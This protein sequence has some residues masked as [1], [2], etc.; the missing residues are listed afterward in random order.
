MIEEI[1]E[2]TDAVIGQASQLLP[3]G[4]PADL[5][6][7]IFSGMKKHRAKLAHMR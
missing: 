1:I 5:V 3:E 4:F 2:S 7:A 6:E